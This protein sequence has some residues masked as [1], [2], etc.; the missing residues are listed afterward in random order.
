M[1]YIKRIDIRGFKTF[2]KKVSIGL[3]RGFTVITGPNGS[4]KSNILDALKFSLGEL[5]PKE[6]RG[7]TLSDLVHKSQG[8][9]SRSAHVAV[10]FD[11]ADRKIPVDSDLVTVS[12]EFTKGGEGVYR[13]NGRRLSR[14]Q[15]QDILSSA[16]I[17]VTG[18]NM[19]AQHAITRLAE[20][21]P[22]ER[23]RILEDL[24]GIGIFEA[25][26]SQ[27]LNELR[28]ADTNLKV[29]AGKV[30]EVRARI[31]ALER[32]RNDLLRHN[33][34][35]KEVRQQEATILS[36]RI[37]DLESKKGIILK[38]L[39]EE[40]KNLEA[41]RSERETITQERS[42]ISEERRSFEETTVNKG[43]EELFKIEREIA[44][45]STDLVKAST[46][47][48]SRKTILD[49]RRKQLTGLEKK[50]T[51][52]E[53]SLQT[54]R[55]SQHTLS[56]RH[57]SLAEKLAN[58]TS[59]LNQLDQKLQSSRALLSTDS[60]KR[61]S[62]NDDIEALFRELGKLS[63]S[64]KGSSTRLELTAGHLQSLELRQKEF[65]SFAEQLK[66][67]IQE[68]ERLEK[69]EE[70]RLVDLEEKVKEYGVLR[71]KRKVEIEEALAV[72]KKARVTV[73][74]FNTQKNLAETFGAEERAIER[75]EE[76]A[77]EGA[78]KGVVGR[79]EDLVK[80]SDENRKAVVAA[81]AGWLKSLVV[82]D[83]EVAIKCV[84]SLKRAKLGRAKIVPLDLE[85]PS[86][87][88]DFDDIPGIVGPLSDV[89]KADKH[90]GAAI[91]FVFG[92]TLL[93]TTQRAAFT[94][95]SRGLRC[96]VISGDLYEPG[97]A[98]E[99]GYYRAPFDV[100]N[101]V[102]RG[103]ALEGLEKTVRSLEQIV[104][105]QRG[106]VDRLEV[107]LGRLREDRVASSKTREALGGEVENERRMLE[108]TR[109]ALHQTK[110]RMESLESMMKRET[111]TLEEMANK[112]GEMKRRL[113]ALE[114]ERA[115]LRFESKQATIIDLDRERGQLAREVEGLAREKL[116]AE[117]HLEMSKSTLETLRPGL[118]NVRIEMRN[119][120]ADV[121]RE[122][123]RVAEAEVVM[124]SSRD[125]LKTLEKTKELL[126]ER[127]GSVNEERRQYETR[128]QDME[129]ALRVFLER[130]DPI[131][132]RVADLKASLREAETQLAMLSAQL[133]DLGF[134][135]PVQGAVEKMEEALEWKRVLMEEV[136]E[137]GLVNQL[138]L[139]QYDGQKD[140]YKNLSVRI[141]QLEQ[142]KL[143]IIEFMNDLERQKRDTFMTAYNK[144]NDTFQKLFGEMTDSKGNGKMVLDNPENP[145]DGGLELMLQF[146]GKP[147]LTIGSASGG[148]KS[149][150]TVCY[151]LALQQIH[152]MPF[153]VMDE[154]DAHLDVVNSRRLATLIRSRSGESQFIVISLK[155][156]TI[157]RAERVYGV[158]AEKGMSNVVSLPALVGKN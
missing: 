4:G 56:S 100:T 127:L 49:T 153:Y 110:H 59:K 21:S 19:I 119:L 126:E 23:R 63:V 130:M 79:L 55:E 88:T 14:K 65:S 109:T 58:A 12:R 102:P 120:E 128:L 64:S 113:S 78:I 41:T 9:G 69:Q 52:M 81:S 45:A 38:T 97:G 44:Q 112:Q 48:E 70:K 42:K 33:L 28:E 13:V 154:I 157:S 101:L 71:E 151:L 125:Q 7:R 156:T 89:V 75:I 26:K 5:S 104:Q 140:N 50:S 43:S 24:I 35:Q 149:V 129:K 74:E 95:A 3:D 62:L 72:A 68:M 143:K 134:D 31:E 22:E 6:L 118:D 61:K 17:Q 20:L 16:D 18:F 87:E 51:E 86:F 36:G 60:E 30:E 25:K 39:N 15:V 57:S 132:A 8:E 53:A 54:H 116:E 37:L 131:N 92:D 114:N 122:E 121:R 67:R 94:A 152:P 142:E 145:F 90:L 82:R 84:E 133:R 98:L 155:D 80:Y 47:T 99:S 40:S 124:V 148:E 147:L 107:E 105:K 108:R 144:V 29:A 150:S 76:M 103:S 117:G 27:S 146:P 73:V 96:V 137:I 2:S 66:E 135:R 34:L 93:A 91:E 141:T 123:A 106:D 10:Q 11:N 136:N 77:K 85:P 32:E 139:E 158:Y 115:R 111:S 1:V 138:A 46:E 83:L